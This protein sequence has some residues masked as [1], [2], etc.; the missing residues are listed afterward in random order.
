MI[1]I[2]FC[3]GGYTITVQALLSLYPRLSWPAWLG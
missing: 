3:H 1:E 2:L